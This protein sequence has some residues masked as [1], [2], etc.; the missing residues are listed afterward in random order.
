MTCQTSIFASKILRPE[1]GKI[2]LED[3]IGFGGGDINL[4]GYVWNSP[5]AYVDPLGLN[6]WGTNVAD[7]LIDEYCSGELLGIQ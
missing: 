1:A 4:Y 2:Y 5:L 6:G 3:P 7:W